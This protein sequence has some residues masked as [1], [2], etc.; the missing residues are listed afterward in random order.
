MKFS[1][2]EYVS[3]VEIGMFCCPLG[4][5]NMPVDGRSAVASQGKMRWYNCIYKITIIIR[6][7]IITIGYFAMCVRGSNSRQ[8][9]LS[10]FIRCR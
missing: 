1:R 5:F 9:E 8:R 7:H 3:S 2:I 6:L 4:H 10:G